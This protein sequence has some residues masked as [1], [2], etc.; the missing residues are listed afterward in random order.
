MITKYVIEIYN[1]NRKRYIKVG[2]WK[3]MNVA[4]KQ[5]DKRY[6]RKHTRRLKMIREDILYTKKLE[7]F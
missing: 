6:Y 5:F 3:Y 4:E 1:S 7:R 2:E